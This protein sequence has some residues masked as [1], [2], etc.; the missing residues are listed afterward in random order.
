MRIPRV[1]IAD[2]TYGLNKTIID[3]HI[4]L[5]RWH[6]RDEAMFEQQYRRAYRVLGE[7]GGL[8][9][10][11]RRNLSVPDLPDGYRVY[12]FHVG[13]PGAKVME[14]L[15][16]I[17]SAK[18]TLEDWRHHRAISPPGPVFHLSVRV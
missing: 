13:S 3:A 7:S 16:Q 4:S 12:T 14:R 1:L 5:G 6:I 9:V 11:A 2:Q 10:R 8:H 17:L 18:Q 15:E